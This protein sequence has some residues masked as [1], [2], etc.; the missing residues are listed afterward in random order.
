MF[1]R[2][3]RGDGSYRP[4]RVPAIAA[5]LNCPPGALFRDGVFAEL[6]LARETIEEV[7]NGGRPAAAAVAERLARRLE[8][9]IWRIATQKPVDPRSG[10]RA[11]PRLS[12]AEVLAGVAEARKAAQKRRR[13]LTSIS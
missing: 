10:A 12:R 9:E 2:W 13:E 5:A 1:S 8:P 3:E 11:K 4:W 7:R 6:A